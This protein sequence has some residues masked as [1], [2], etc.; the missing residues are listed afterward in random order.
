MFKAA[1]RVNK[2][3][4]L[5]QLRGATLH[6]ERADE[7][8]RARLREGAEPGAGLAWSKAENDRDYLGAFKAHKL[9]LEARERKSAPPLPAGPMRR[10]PGMGEGSGRSAR[11]PEPPQSRPVR[12][13]E[14]MGRKLGR[15]GSR[16]SARASI[17]M[18]P[19]A[20]WWI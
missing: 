13:S 14:G 2:I 10:L 17:W 8:S 7:T 12:P 1:V 5:A 15:E 11:P 20:R 4:T 19:A 16:F 6:A 9:E 18:K 3:T